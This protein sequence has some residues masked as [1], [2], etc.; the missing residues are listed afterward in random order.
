MNEMPKTNVTAFF[1]LLVILLAILHPIGK[2]AEFV[3]KDDE[4]WSTVERGFDRIESLMAA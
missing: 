2:A 3:G 1:V 4:Y